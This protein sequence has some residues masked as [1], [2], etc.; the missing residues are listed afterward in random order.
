MWST[1]VRRPRAA[2]RSDPAAA[3]SLR[4][5]RVASRRTR[6]GARATGRA[7]RTRRVPIGSRSWRLL[8]SR[9]LSRVDL[10][11]EAEV[12]ADRL[13]DVECGAGR[14]DVGGGED[15]GV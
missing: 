15:A 12:E 13:E 3:R 11:A 1:P 14:V 8:S 5:R 2:P 6:P 9:L 4:R 10:R 7:R